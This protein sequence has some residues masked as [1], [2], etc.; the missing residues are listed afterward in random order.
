MS[1]VVTDPVQFS[2]GHENLICFHRIKILICNLSK[3]FL[4]PFLFNSLTSATLGFPSPTLNSSTIFCVWWPF[5]TTTF[6]V[7]EL[8]PLAQLFFYMQLPT[9]AKA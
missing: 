6:M 5:S 3:L 7:H 1:H 9:R 4:H 2:F 8:F